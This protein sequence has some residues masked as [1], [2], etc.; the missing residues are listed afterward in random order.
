MT[1][2]AIPKILERLFGL[3]I[4]EGEVINILNQMA[5]AF[6]PYY[7]RLIQDIRNAPARYT[8]E[9]SWRINGKKSCGHS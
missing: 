6:G 7:E 1:E 2:E 8:D 4:S 5:D 9:T 3:K